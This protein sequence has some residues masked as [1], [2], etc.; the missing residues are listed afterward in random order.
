MNT[1]SMRAPTQQLLDPDLQTL[2]IEAGDDWGLDRS[3]GIGGSESGSVLGL[4]K[5]RGTLELLEEKITG[6]T[7]EFT[8]AQELRMACGHALELLTLQTFAREVLEVPYCED[9]EDLDHSD[10]L[11][12]PDRY[13]Y[14]NPRHPFAFAH[15]DG[16]Y[17]AKGEIGIVDAKVSFRSPWSEA[18]EYYIT[19]LAHYC[20]VLGVN[21]GFIAGMF[22][23][24]PF[25]IPQ[26]YR[27]DFL[28]AQL[29][30][31][32]K[33]ER[34]FW[35]G[36]TAIRNG[37]VPSES[38]LGAFEQ[39]L[40]MMGEEFMAGIEVPTLDDRANSATVT[41]NNE[42]LVSLQRYAELKNQVRLAYREI[43]E[44]SDGL[45]EAVDAPNISFVLP[46]GT[47]AAKKT[48]IITNVLDK[49]ALADAG[50]PVDAF[51]TP[52][53]QMRLTTT[54]ALTKLELPTD[55]ALMRMRA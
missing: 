25:P 9:L 10:G 40:G 12:R 29:E 47:L 8:Q 41:V 19:Q 21:V 23:D 3:Q 46:D 37:A 20:A 54:K 24:Q 13:L 55:I 43:G 51:Y 49:G 18:P 4:N 39:R 50:I 32:M 38:R 53:E 15:I 11:T 6:K 5:Y 44:I 34:I 28:P 27:I 26:H 16:L 48:T 17:R 45:K 35:N 7:Q 22:M 1:V 31:V 2:R 42:E 52:S 33:A 14:L 36:V 30:L